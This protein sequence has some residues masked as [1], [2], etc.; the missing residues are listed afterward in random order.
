MSKI[1]RVELNKFYEHSIFCPFCGA[2]VID[3]EA[4]GKDGGEVAVN[5]CIHT[6]FVAHD[7]GFE[8]RS[9]RFDADAGIL[10][11]ADEGIELPEH[12]YDG[13]TDQVAIADSIKF[14]SYVGMPS[15]FGSYVGFAP[16]DP[17]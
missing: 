5:A 4:A 14:A 1:Q 15:G 3:M 8:Y 7:E 17:E 6:L 2:K 16:V 13:L 9:E 12:G 10:G 11:I